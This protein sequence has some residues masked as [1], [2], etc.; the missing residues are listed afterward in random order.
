[1]AFMRQK[2]IR[3]SQLI[4]PW[5]VGAIVPFPEDE[6][7]MIAGL[8]MWRYLDPREY[9]IH[10]ER[11]ERRLGVSELRRPPDFREP[12]PGVGNAKLYIP[13]ARFPTWQYCPFC[14]TM[15]RGSFF[16]QQEHCDAYQWQDGRNC[17]Q[18]RKIGRRMIPERFI[19]VCPD[20]HIDDFPIME[21]VHENP[22]NPKR[23]V[24]TCRLR[25]STGGTS[26]ALTGVYY[27]CS[28]GAGRS[29]AGAT[30]PGAL[31]K[32][33][34]NCRGTKPW[35]G[36]DEDKDHPCGR[37]DVRVIQR[38]GTNVWFGDIR[39]SIFIPTTTSD[40]AMILGL[41]RKYADRISARKQDPAYDFFLDFIAE[42][43]HV[44][45]ERFKAAVKAWFNGQT[46]NTTSDINESMTEEEYRL[47]EYRVLKTDSGAD[48]TD[49]HSFNH[50]I[51]EYNNAIRPFF[52]SVSIIPKL[53]ETRALVGFSRLEPSEGQSVEDTKKM[54]RLGDG[55]WLPAIDVYGEGIFFEFNGEKLEQWAQNPLILNRVNRMSGAY[56]LMR[57]RNHMPAN[58]L[59]PRYVLIHT[60]A[61]LLINQLSYEC[62]YGSSSIRERIYCDREADIHGM[63]GVLIYTASGDSDGS[64]GGLVKQGQPGHIEDVILTAVTNA[65]WCSAD[66]VCIESMGQGPDSCNLA[67]CHNCSLL[68][69][70]CCETGN[71]YL[72]RAMLIGTLNEQEIGYF[73]MR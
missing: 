27:R 43:N 44:D 6:S 42:E 28:C 73:H 13:A 67:A 38:G 5:G 66:P 45:N 2:P 32:V 41:V 35:L 53:R 14:G 72:D 50:S 59:N 21:W 25:R 46:P 10:D 55:D 4:S 17:S 3:S 22:A 11:L 69:E 20:G 8:D 71:R 64:L 57:E 51:S 24:D 19:V 37:T 68:P 60:F 36:I 52:K 7:V 26:A 39:S 47:A 18:N 34:Y 70:T 29:M 61:H 48:N 33:G 16:S 54:L 65:E 12:M 9:V 15:K 63:H 30:A 23:I 62:G 40:D 49:F 31:G 58:E 1:M 56:K